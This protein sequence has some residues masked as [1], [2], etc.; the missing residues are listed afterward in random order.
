MD[1]FESDEEDCKGSIDE[2]NVG[3]VESG[4]QIYGSGLIVGTG[5]SDEIFESTFQI[6]PDTS[7]GK[8]AG[9]NG[10]GRL[11][12][13]LSTYEYDSSESEEEAVPFG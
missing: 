4:F 9:I 1:I 5:S 3:G 11:E 12:V 7:T 8:Y 10:S 2:S 13:E 6:T